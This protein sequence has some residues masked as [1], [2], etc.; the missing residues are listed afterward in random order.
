MWNSDADECVCDS[1][2]FAEAIADG[3]DGEYE[4]QVCTCQADAMYDY[5]L[6]RD[7]GYHDEVCIP[8]AGPGESLE[9]TTV[10]YYTK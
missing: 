10:L 1:E 4:G 2:A 5:N 7:Q 8:C 3:E 6:N 9:K